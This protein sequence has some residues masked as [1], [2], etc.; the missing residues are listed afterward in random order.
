MANPWIPERLRGQNLQSKRME[1]TDPETMVAQIAKLV[2]SSELGPAH[3]SIRNELGG[4]LYETDLPAPRR[5]SKF[6]VVYDP[7]DPIRF[8][9]QEDWYETF[10]V[11]EAEGMTFLKKAKAPPVRAGDTLSLSPIRLR[12]DYV[13]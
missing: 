7:I 4:K 1:P 3:L 11:L 5:E 13:P 8:V 2:L 10:M 6:Y 12:I 9:A